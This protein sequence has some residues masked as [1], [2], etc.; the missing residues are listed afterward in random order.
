VTLRVN[1]AEMTWTAYRDRIS[2]G[3]PVLLPVGALEQHGPHMAMG[4]DHLVPAAICREVA[5]GLGGIVAPAIAYGYKSQPRMGGGNDFPGTTSLDAAHLVG[6]I[7]D[8]ICE[9]AR[10]GA[11]RIAVV[12]G[13]YENMMF[14]I[15]AVDLALRD[16]RRDGI[17]DVTLVRCEYW[18]YTRTATLNAVFPD[19]FPGWALEH[20][21]VF[22]T[23]L[24]LHLH[25]DMVQMDLVPDEPPASFPPHDTHPLPPGRVPPSGVL[26]PARTATAEKGRFLF[27]NQVSD[28]LAALR[29]EFRL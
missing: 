26:S 17:D 2:K 3:S 20:A 16:L 21:A 13:H 12:N 25:P 24:M 8:V 28:L 27:E 19:G 22:E 15:E 4:V 11:R 10:H 14:T 6:I 9:L 7:R 18:D 5:Q 29:A 1:M 23:S